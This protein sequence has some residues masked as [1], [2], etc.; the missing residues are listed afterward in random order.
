MA[1]SVYRFDSIIIV[2]RKS[3]DCFKVR[4]HAFEAVAETCH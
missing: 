1:L 2:K 3:C 4:M